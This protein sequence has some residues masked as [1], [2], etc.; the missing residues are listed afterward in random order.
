[1]I[2]VDL[3]KMLVWGDTSQDI[4][5]RS[6]DTVFIP[7]KGAE[8]SIDGLVKRPAIYE[9]KGAAALANV[10]ELAGGLKAAALK[11][12]SVSRFSENGM[13]VFN[14]NLANANDRNFD[15]RDGDKIS[16]KPSNTEYS[17]AITLKGAVVRD[18]VFSYQPGMRISRMLQNINRDLTKQADLAYAL[19]VREVDAQRNIEVLQFNLGNALANPGSADD[20]AL[21]ARDS[22]LI[23]NRN[24]P[25]L[26]ARE[27]QQ[28]AQLAKAWANN[29]SN[30][31]VMNSAYATGQNGASANAQ[32]AQ[33][34]NNSAANGNAQQGYNQASSSDQLAL[35]A[36][37]N[38]QQQQRVTDQAT[39]AQVRQSELNRDEK[40]T[41]GKLSETSDKLA[42]VASLRE[43]LLL[44]VIEQLKS[45]AAQGKPIQVVEVRGEV[46]FPGVYPLASN[47][48]STQAL[49]AAAGGLTEK[50]YTIELA[51]VNLQGESMAMQHQ[52]LD[53]GT[54]NSVAAPAMQSKDSLNVLPHPQWRN[55]ATVQVFGEVKYPGT[56]SVRRGETLH[57]L[58]ARVGGIT[59]Y[60]NPNGTVFAREQLRKQEEER[61]NAM[62]EELKQEIATMTLRRQSSIANYSSTPSEAMKVVDQL[63]NSRAVGRMTIDMPAILSGEKKADLMLQDGDKLYIPQLQNVVS[64]QGMVQY[65]SA[66]V[67]DGDLSVSDYLDKA[68]G[69]RT[70][71]DDDRIYV[72]KANGS[73]MLPGSSW[74]GRSKGLEPGDT[75]V[76]PVDSAYLDNLSIMTSATQILYQIGVAWN[77]IK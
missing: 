56:Y 63:Q 62:R 65:P 2:D 15:V 40:M 30:T 76:V 35:Q 71:A 53:L 5:L 66:H 38:Q 3:Y 43:E 32:N 14:L 49:L 54:A 34:A 18:G 50:A 13:R 33:Y 42:Q 39:G 44:P 55:E 8:V 60:A 23:F 25:E 73:V 7:A 11:E 10:L 9:L 29:A 72:I 31:A 1:V 28:Q 74:F 21:Q 48:R 12:V 22:V 24:V 51:R 27:K 52:R 77:A 6:G 68:G 75:I 41:L 19:V 47:Q 45:Q 67:F 70:Q 59:A 36:Q 58:L 57:D 17:Q 69:L 46:K 37:M 64:I 4:R 26:S 20:L 16:V 61:I